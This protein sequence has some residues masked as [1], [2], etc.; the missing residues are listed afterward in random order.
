MNW[1]L[2]RQLI[3]SGIF[4]SF[5]LIIFLIFYLSRPPL[6]A[7]CF[8]S[9]KNQVEE[10]VDCGGPCP[11]C[12]L[13]TAQPLEIYPV[14]FLAYSD[15]IDIIGIVKNPNSNLALK[16][17]K[18]YFEIYDIN[19]ILKATTTLKETILEP[20]QK[21]YLLEINYPKPSFIIGKIKLRIL[22]PEDKDWIKVALEKPK[23]SFYNLKID[24]ENNKLKFSVT[25][26][27]QTFI[28]YKDM[29]IIVFL[30]NQNNNLIGTTK[31]LL[32]L[33]PQ[34]IKDLIL[35]FPL[36][37]FQPTSFELFFQRTNLER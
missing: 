9:K 31:S 24:E 17:L 29:E 35:F 21:R 19:D 11:P 23:I 28:T 16:K 10:D 14:Q 1:R 30:Y 3:Y 6:P 13:K 32:T 2:R 26:F 27:N 36:N 7:S 37:N 15:S 34:E 22:K 8:D 25:F 33:N 20:D 5:L 4:F 18:Y 12:E